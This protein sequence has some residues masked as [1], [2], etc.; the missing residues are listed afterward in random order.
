VVESTKAASDVYAPV[1]GEIV[2]ANAD[3]GTQPELVNESPY[4]KGWLFKLKLANKG[5]LTELL[6]RDAY[7]KSAGVV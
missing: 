1:T 7:K 5:E 6:S 4:Q 3:L 2:D